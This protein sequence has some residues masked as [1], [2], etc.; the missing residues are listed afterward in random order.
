MNL[1]TDQLTMRER[2]SL[3]LP[4]LANEPGLVRDRIRVRRAVHAFNNSMP[5][6]IEP[7]DLKAGEA[8][9][10]IGGSQNDAEAPPDVMGS[11]RRKLLGDI[12]HMSP[13]KLGA[14]EV[15]P[16]FWWC[17]RRARRRREKRAKT[18]GYAPRPAKLTPAA[19]LP[20]TQ[21]QRLRLQYQVRGRLLL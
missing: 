16:P 1:Q 10:G 4:Y 21:W 15:E 8:A 9:R 12:L 3:G 20:V 13:A 7:S 17:V 19:C 11:E 14:V 18:R 5:S 2:A 6:D